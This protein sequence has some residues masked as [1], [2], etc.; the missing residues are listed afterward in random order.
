MTVQDGLDDEVFAGRRVLLIVSGGI[1][2]YKALELI[3]R[4]KERGVQ[5]RCVLTE[6]GSHFITPLSVAALSGEQCY[7]DLWSLKDETEMGHIRLTREADLVVVAPAS[8]DILARMACGLANDLA[9]TALL[10]C[11]KP[12]LV[13]PAMNMQMW[14]NPATQANVGV[15]R[16]RGIL[17]VGPEAGDL[18][19]GEVGE[20][21]MS[22]P[23]QILLALG[24]IFGALAGARP[25]PLAGRSAIVTSGPTRE[26]L[27][28]VRYITNRS[29]GRQGHA[30]A[31]ALARLGARV[32]LVSGPVALPDPAGIKT[33]HVETAEQMLAAVQQ[34][35]PADIAVM[36]AA[37]ADWR[38]AQPAETKL[39]KDGSAGLSV[40]WVQN[41][42]I[43]A[44]VSR[45]GPGRPQLV[46]GFAAETE[47][48]EEYGRDKLRRKGCDWLVANDVSLESGTFDGAD[49]SLHLLRYP[50]GEW[51]R[52]TRQ[53]KTQAAQQLAQAIA[54]ELAART[55]E[56]AL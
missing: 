54:E 35:L 7:T 42:D 34:A 6:A 45:R 29:S 55:E 47:R 16:D 32:T 25:R 38:A 28:P 27:D 33:V 18:A 4:L 46:V 9:T 52:W 56:I 53:S 48:L 43:L 37:V 40:D 50:D 41:P 13:A 20:G 12:V 31:Q 21:R 22:D 11:D 51:E 36:A 23:A 24:R 19:C 3:R 39:K 2:A 14:A 26:P 15:L 10:A 1:A 8:A 17:M 5:V 44:T 30:I 49:N